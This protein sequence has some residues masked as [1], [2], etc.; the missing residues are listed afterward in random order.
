[1]SG[2]DP[3]R[4]KVSEEAL[5]Y[6]LANPLVENLLTVPGVGPVT[7]DRLA[8]D[9]IRTTFQLLGAFLR[10]C[11]EG[12]TTQERTDAFWFYLQALEVPGGTRSSIVHSIAEKINIMVPGLYGD[13]EEEDDEEEDDDEDAST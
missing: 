12:M 8:A 11:D 3:T 5:A 10:V 6:F 9:G 1:M 13:D 7:V 4:S 2:F